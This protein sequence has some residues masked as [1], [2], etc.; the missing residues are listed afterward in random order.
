MEYVIFMRSLISEFSYGF[1]LTHEFVQAMGTLSAAPIFPSLIS[2]GAAG[3][4]YDVKLEQPGLP[5]FIQFKRSECIKLM[6]GREIK[7][8]ADLTTPY[9]RFPVTASA[10]SDQHDMLLEWDVAQNEVFYAAPMF[11]TKPEFDNA[12]LSGE[13]RQRSFFVRPRMIGR[14]IDDKT[15]HV[16]FDG[17][18][19]F[20]MSKPFKI[21][22]M[23]LADL[24]RHFGAKLRDQKQPLKNQLPDILGSARDVRNTIREREAAAQSRRE[25][26]WSQG[27]ILGTP[28]DVLPEISEASPAS[29]DG[30]EITRAEAFL[31][32]QLCQTALNSFQVTASKS[33]HFV[34]P[35]SAVFFAA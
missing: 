27:S 3:G 9:Y 8:G 17:K 29:T 30:K 5:I 20:K 21:E 10:D 6:S 14:F 32:L 15:H 26:K 31:R 34:S 19:C 35:L 12:F 33:F 4:G 2:E 18:N 13:V 25:A 28:S 16:A 24:E 1:A 7:N 22:A 11:H 23:G